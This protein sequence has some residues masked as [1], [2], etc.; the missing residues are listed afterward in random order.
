MTATLAV[1]APQPVTA[2]SDRRIERVERS[3][4]VLEFALPAAAAAA[5]IG[6]A[7][8]N[9]LMQFALAFGSTMAVTQTMKASIDATRPNGGSRSMP[10]GHT[11]SA[12]SASTFVSCRYGRVLGLPMLA[13]S[14]F[15]AWSRV[16]SDNHYTRDVLVGATIATGFTYLFVDRWKD[17]RVRPWVNGRRYGMQIQW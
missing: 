16:V 8:W 1:L 9:G 12:F 11:A 3:G 17:V 10:S 7:D 2:N 15:T 13:L 6:F 4:D 5:S 14:T